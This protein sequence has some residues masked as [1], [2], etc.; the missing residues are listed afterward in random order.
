VTARANN[1]FYPDSSP[2]FPILHQTSAITN[3][4]SAPRAALIWLYNLA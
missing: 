4:H 3:A 1:E 2:A